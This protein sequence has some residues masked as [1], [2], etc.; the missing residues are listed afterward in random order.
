[1]NTATATNGTLAPNAHALTAPGAQHDADADA[2]AKR[3]AAVIDAAAL[4]RA[5][6]TLSKTDARIA[7]YAVASHDEETRASLALV[8]EGIAVALAAIASLPSMLVDVSAAVERGKRPRNG[9]IE[10][11]S[12]VRIKPKHRATF[13]GVASGEALASDHTVAS[14]NDACVFLKI[15]DTTLPLPRSKV[16]LAHEAAFDPG[17]IVRIASKHVARIAADFAIEAGALSDLTVAACNGDKVTLRAT[18]GGA[19]YMLPNVKAAHV[20]RC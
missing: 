1:M 10:A 18:V 8:R 2:D 20:E 15:G 13:A 17:E 6:A 4:T 16:E 19:P 14:V 7:A 11:G 3:P 9:T 5:S 12:V